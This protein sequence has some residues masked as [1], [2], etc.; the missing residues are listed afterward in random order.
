MSLRFPIALVL[1]ILCL[2]VPA[3]ADFQAALDAY[4][5]GDYATALSEVLPVWLPLISTIL[6]ALFA[7]SLLIQ[8]FESGLPLYRKKPE[9]ALRSV[10]SVIMRY[11][12]R[13]SLEENKW[14]RIRL[15]GMPDSEEKAKAAGMKGYLSVKV[16]E[17]FSSS[18]E[19]IEYCENGPQMRIQ[20]ADVTEAAIAP[21]EDI[22]FDRYYYRTGI[23]RVPT[24]FFDGISI[25]IGI[26]FL[27]GLSGYFWVWYLTTTYSVS[28]EIAIWWVGI[29]QAIT[30][31]GFVVYNWRDSPRNLSNLLFASIFG[32]IPLGLL[33]PG[34]AGMFF[35]SPGWALPILAVL[36]T[37]MYVLDRL[38]IIWK[39][40][41]YFSE[42]LWPGLMAII[43]L[44]VWALIAWRFQ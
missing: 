20:Y 18:C 35:L 33:G 14:V 28:A 12:A 34:L 22:F 2:A 38:G 15:L 29:A 8:R 9:I 36:L 43:L 44:I 25:V 5:H 32:M 39:I 17:C 24:Y 1:L 26:A 21:E 6:A 11:L 37:A 41:G 13:Q 4:N 7:L 3:W 16:V 27:L 19:T 42:K 30:S 31:T 23:R 40:Q 10:N